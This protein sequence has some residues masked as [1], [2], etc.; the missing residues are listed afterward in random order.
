MAEEEEPMAGRLLIVG[1][2]P[3]PYGGIASQIA[4]TAPYF[5]AA[6][7]EK[8]H[9]LSWAT[10][11]SSREEA[12]LTLEKVALAQRASMMANPRHW[13]SALPMLA[14][15]LSQRLAPR[16]A[17]AE[18]TRAAYVEKVL[19]DGR[20]DIVHYF[21]LTE[22]FIAPVIRRRLPHV[23]QVVT[24]YG[25]IF[26]HEELFGTRASLVRDQLA[27]V[28]H[29]LSSSR[30]CA[31]S[32][33]A[34]GIPSDDIEPLYY[35]VDLERFSPGNDATQ[36]RREAG[37]SPDSKLIF[38]F[39]RLLAQMGAD[40][41]ADVVPDVLE[42]NGDA[43]FLLAGADGD[44]VPRFRELEARYPGRIHLRVNVPGGEVP[45]MYA[46]C[47]LL[48]APTRERHACMG[49]SIKEAMASGRVGIC[50]RSGGIP[51]AV[52]DGETGILLPT[53]PDLRVK[54]ADMTA[55]IL[56]MLAD[57][58]RRQRMG[59]AARARAEA[60]FD[61][62]QTAARLVEIYRGLLSA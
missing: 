42:A 31:Q 40:V 62:R 36:F 19:R 11:D 16:N 26:D 55:A 3:P 20:Y 54:P 35:G 56:D 30:Y 46:A 9:I 60:I 29:R 51:E 50:S 12:G 17:V 33:E 38:F 34:L 45:K 28:D 10:E 53:G 23:R 18:A 57:D 47:D 59:V 48:L 2:Y 5:V 58:G 24:V 49:M 8:V 21:M 61:N 7:F 44:C 25:E 32:V 41:V 15:G 22:G 14:R 13:G 27:A 1:P 39:A 4:N 43:V 6:G 52:I 37:I